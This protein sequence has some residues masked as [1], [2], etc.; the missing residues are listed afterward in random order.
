MKKEACSF[1]RDDDD[2]LL[3]AIFPP[4]HGG[5]L[6]IVC[7]RP[8]TSCSLNPRVLMV[9]FFCDGQNRVNG[10][11]RTT[12]DEIL[13][14]EKVTRKSSLKLIVIWSS[15][16]PG[17]ASLEGGEKN[18]R[19]LKLITS[20]CLNDY[21]GNNS[22]SYFFLWEILVQYVGSSFMGVLCCIS[23]GPSPR[24]DGTER[25]FTLYGSLL[26]VL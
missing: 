6:R 19:A 15:T 18:R 12:T 22:I 2:G 25:L 5:I 16:L 14:T 8:P 4:F 21:G 24:D 10:S 17:G 9:P 20:C 1:P 3:P 7:R 23:V 11:T 26:R 13:S